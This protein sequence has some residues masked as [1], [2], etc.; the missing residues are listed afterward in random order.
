M[1]YLHNI[2]STKLP[3]YLYQ[4]IPPLQRSHQYPGCFQ[5]FRCR[6][7][8][9]QNSFLPFAITEWNKL[10]S[11]IKNIDSHALF[12]KKL[13]AFIRPLGN[14]KYGIYEPLGIRLLNRV[15]L[16][17][18]HLREHKFRDNFVHTLNPLYS[19]SLK[20]EDTEH[21]FLRC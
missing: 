16:G 9:F 19:C 21:D 7:T 2:I 8:F 11:D 10:D 5:T 15:R 1:S 12:R 4:L 14:D 18:S 20:T 17:F 13:L 3:P 6:T